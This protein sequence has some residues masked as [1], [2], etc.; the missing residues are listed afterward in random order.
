[1]EVVRGGK[2]SKGMDETKTTTTVTTKKPSKSLQSNPDTKNKI[3]L[4][5]HQNLQNV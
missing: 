4:R 3:E 5:H 2:P 1:M